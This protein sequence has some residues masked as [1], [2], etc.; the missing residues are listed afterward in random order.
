MTICERC[1]LFSRLNIISY[2]RK[3]KKGREV[4][5]AMNFAPVQRDNYPLA[6]PKMGRYEEVFSTDRYEYG[7]R[8]VLN[9]TPVRTRTE[10]DENGLKHPII[11]IVLPPL[12]GVIYRKQQNNSSDGGQYV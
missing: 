7:G 10:T 11:D 8:N 5:V 3:D 12:G 1:R 4:I 9:E 2:R 6:V